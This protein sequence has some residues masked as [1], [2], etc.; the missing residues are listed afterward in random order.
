M[1]FGSGTL[2]V[3]YLAFFVGLVPG[4][5]GSGSEVFAFPA[6]PCTSRSWWD[7]GDYGSRH[8]AAFEH[9]LTQI[10]RFLTTSINRSCV[11]ALQRA[12]QGTLPRTAVWFY[13]Q[14]SEALA[15]SYPEASPCSP[16]SASRVSVL[17]GMFSA[18]LFLRH[19]QRLRTEG[20]A[21][22]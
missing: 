4:P 6:L 15:A 17:A 2:W 11:F 3:C 10:S 7:E 9:Y 20:G 5:T 8:G 21:P 16:S 22:K 1:L 18:R 13:L 14:I 19:G 12:H